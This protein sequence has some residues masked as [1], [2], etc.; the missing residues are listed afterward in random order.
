MGKESSTKAAAKEKA[1]KKKAKEQA[2]KE[3]AYKAKEKADK[4]SKA[5][6]AK[7]KAEEKKS[8]ELKQKEKKAKADAHERATKLAKERKSKNTCTLTAYEHNNY[9]GRVLH[10]HHTC[11]SKASFHLPKTGRRRGYEASSFRLSSGCQMV[12]LWDEDGCRENY[13]D[14]V[15]IR[16]SVGSVKW[17]LNDDIC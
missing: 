7:G 14:N 16:S 2:N 17:D 10:T 11:A 5:R 15:N 12:Q 9:R 8:K 6:E 3:K 4:A 1:D 13:G